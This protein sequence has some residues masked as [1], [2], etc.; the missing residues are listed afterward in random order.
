MEHYKSVHPLK[1]YQDYLAHDIRPDGRG[2]N[3]FRNVAINVDSISSANGSTI[4]RIGNTC[5]VCGIKGELGPPK[6]EEPQNGFLIINVDLPPLCSSQFRP[7]PPSEKAQALTAYINNI[8]QRSNIIDLKNLCIEAD[9]LVWTV[10]CDIV[11]LNYDGSVVD[12]CLASL[13]GSI[14]SVTLPK[15]HYNAETSVIS[16]DEDIPIPLTVLCKPIATSFAIF[17][18][19][20]ILADPCGEEESL[21]N[22]T[23]TVIIANDELHSIHK[24]GGNT[25]S[26]QQIQKCTSEAKERT[27]LIYKLI[28]AAM[29]QR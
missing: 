3:K 15:V 20:I 24:P 26:E 8:A 17:N 6:A 29:K 27:I 21:S 18:D 4:V 11:C 23:V 13:I 25:L 16:V 14:L 7:G 22:G 5:V 10:Y 28:Q 12:A 1:Y 19:D 9:K 2:L